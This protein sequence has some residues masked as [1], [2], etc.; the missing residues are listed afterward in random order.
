MCHVIKLLF[1]PGWCGSVDWAPACKAK[2]HWFNSQA[3]HRL[4]LWAR[5]PVGGTQEATTHWCFSP[6]LPSFPCLKIN[7]S[8]F[9]KSQTL[10]LQRRWWNTY[11]S[12]QD[13]SNKATC[14]SSYTRIQRG[15]SRHKQDLGT[16]YDQVPGKPIRLFYC[17]L[18]VYPILKQL[19]C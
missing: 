13:Y 8:F 1:C 12:S 2:G 19:V 17:Q 14:S 15:R 6:F 10:I 18:F 3:G 11:L 5:S 4:G 7:K 9:L 16:S